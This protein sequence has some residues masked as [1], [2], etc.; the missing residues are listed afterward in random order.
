MNIRDRIESLEQQIYVACSEGDYQTV[1]HL[2]QQLE[3]LQGIV[4]H[5]M[6]D[7]GP[8]TLEGKDF[9]DDDWR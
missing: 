4:E 9:L 1:N 8:Y 2:E 7:E 3:H 6:N 5:S